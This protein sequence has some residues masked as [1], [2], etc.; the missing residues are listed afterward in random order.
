MYTSCTVGGDSVQKN[1]YLVSAREAGGVPLPNTVGEELRIQS[2][3]NFNGIVNDF[4]VAA[5]YK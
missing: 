4:Y 1:T 5:K 2:G 3:K